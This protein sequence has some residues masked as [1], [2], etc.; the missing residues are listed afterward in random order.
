MGQFA[1][2]IRSLL[3][4]VAVFVV[5]AALLAWTLGGTLWPKPTIVRLEPVTFASRQ[6]FWQLS[7]GGRDEN[8]IRW[9]LMQQENQ[10]KPQP[11]DSHVWTDAA[12]LFLLD[13]A[14]F[15]A[16]CDDVGRWQIGRLAPNLTLVLHELPDRLAVEQQMARL[17]AGK[18]IQDSQVILAERALVLDPASKTAEENH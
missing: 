12:D 4:K 8:A 9:Q 10:K 13:D 16:G 11:L 14:L 18:A 3:I 5:M 15:L 2:G 7:V 6:W 1:L 17:K